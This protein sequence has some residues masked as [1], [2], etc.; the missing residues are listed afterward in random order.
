[1]AQRVSAPDRRHVTPDEAKRLFDAARQAGRNTTRD[2]TLLMMMYYH[3]L[4][5]SEAVDL[6]WHDIDWSTSH[7]HVRR[8]KGGV[9]STHPLIGDELRA[10][11]AL[12]RE[13]EGKGDFIFMS[14]RGSPLSPDMVARII[15]RAGVIAGL[16]HHM[17]PH[18]LRHG[19]GFALADKGTD[20]R[21][22]QDY[23]GHA[24]ITSTV[25]Y[26]KLS[27]KRFRN[28]F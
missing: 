1:M 18:R 15:E 11:K 25:R 8:V 28:L 21:T 24:S 12:K 14:E 23:L 10:I 27:S 3:G 20:T 5:C 4:R 22:I 9:A 7:L 2:R 26:T 13:T 6:R 19:C 17:H 16:G